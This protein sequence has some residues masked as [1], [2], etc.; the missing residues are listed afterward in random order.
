M[1]D[2][3]GISDI[4]FTL[5]TREIT[6]EELAEQYGF[7]LEF[8]TEKIGVQRIFSAEGEQVSDLACRAV[9]KLIVNHP[10]IRDSIDVLILC[11]QTPDYQ[12]PQ[13]SSQVQAR[14]NLPMTTA[15]FDISLGCSGFV[16]G[17]SVIKSMMEA[18]QF[19]TG[20]LVTSDLYSSLISVDDRQTKPLFSD[21]AT[22]TLISRDCSLVPG[23]FCFGTNGEMFDKLIVQPDVAM[24]SGRRLV[25]DGRAIFNF[26]STVIPQE[27]VRIC[28]KNE[29]R[30][31]EI[32]AFVFH[33][34][35]SYL[36]SSIAR[37]SGIQ[38][39]D[40]ILDRLN[41][42]GNTVSSSIPIVL[43]E[44]LEEINLA[45]R[46]ILL[47]GFGVGLSWAGTVLRDKR[48]T[49]AEDDL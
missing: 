5:G 44:L 24:K 23:Q 47:S 19:D 25:M 28:T 17:L 40:R 10:Y 22:A 14:C 18:N 29:L 1:K 30:V 15:A 41:Q 27:I 4:E 35:S 36:L 33:Q 16:Y 8:I 39:P 34:A 38:H 21:A 13:T 32:D 7:E 3:L 37:R 20:I 2:E 45:R 42:Y 48:S 49:E 46:N 6:A 43:K 9:E 11:T 12:L 26:T 31:D